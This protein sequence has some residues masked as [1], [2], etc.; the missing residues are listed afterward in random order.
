MMKAKVPPTVCGTCVW[1]GVGNVW[2]QKKLEAR[3]KIENAARP[4]GSPTCRLHAVL[5]SI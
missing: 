2:E 5:G 4:S 3:K 1:A